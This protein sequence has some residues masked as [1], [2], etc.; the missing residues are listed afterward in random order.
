[1]VERREN[2]RICYKIGKIKKLEMKA[3]MMRLEKKLILE[4]KKLRK[5]CILKVKM[6]MKK[7]WK[8][9]GG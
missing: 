3:L 4:L 2:M 9:R 8:V 1:M 7:I 6:Q 5:S